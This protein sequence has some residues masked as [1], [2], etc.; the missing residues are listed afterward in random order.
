MISVLCQ[1]E[2]CVVERASIDE[3]YVDL[4]DRVHQLMASTTTPPVT[5]VDLPH[6]FIVGADDSDGKLSP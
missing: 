3:A 5:D 4:T 6:T 2:G 1:F